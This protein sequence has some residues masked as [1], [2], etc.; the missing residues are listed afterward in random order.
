M[1]KH[2][3]IAHAT[4]IVSRSVFNNS[5]NYYEKTRKPNTEHGE[6][7]FPMKTRVP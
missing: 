6:N 1:T 4:C 7:V 3:L 5:M 2:T